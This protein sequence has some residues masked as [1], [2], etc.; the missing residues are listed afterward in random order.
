MTTH[1][2]DILITAAKKA[3]EVQK[4]I[5]RRGS[6]SFDLEKKYDT[7][8]SADFV[9][10]ADIESERVLREYFQEVM[11]EYNLLGEEFG[12]EYNGNGKVI[13]MDPLDATKHFRKGRPRFGPIIGVYERGRNI[14]GIEYNVLQNIIYVGTERT[15]LDRIGSQ[16]DSW[17]QGVV[18]VG[19]KVL[20]CPDFKSELGKTLRHF[21]PDNPIIAKSDEHDV[22]HRA[23]VCDGRW[24][25]YFHAGQGR[26]DIA[27][28]PIFGKLTGTNVTNHNGKPYDFL[29]AELEV[30]KYGTGQNDAVSSS[31]VLVAR[32]PYFEKMLQALAPYKAQLDRRQVPGRRDS[33][34]LPVLKI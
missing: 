29:D 7:G 20:N 13:L 28:A 21:F 5:L 12:G 14:A 19:G 25:V 4:E 30:A 22:L 16:E 24:A 9:T 31:T 34:K 27:A 8:T 2:R 10:E 26:H 6:G 3:G 1:L 18:Y 17:P 23:R 32:E 33:L 15:G 11:P